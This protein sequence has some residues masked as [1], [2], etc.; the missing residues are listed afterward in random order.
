MTLPVDF[1]LCLLA[2]LIAWPV[3]KDISL[4]YAVFAPVTFLI[5]QHP[6]WD[7]TAISMMFA[8]YALIDCMIGMWKSRLV[9]F[10]SSFVWVVV[11]VESLMLLD[12]TLNNLV[13]IDAIINAWLV[14]I[15][16]REWKH[17]MDI[18]RS[19]HSS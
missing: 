2:A 4:R 16:A 6:Y 7:A 17:W 10:V 18:K 3:A 14:I 1:Y 8:T 9:F 11:S 5:D 15:I 13:Y 12:Y 19:S